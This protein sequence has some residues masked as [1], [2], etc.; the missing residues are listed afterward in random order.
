[1]GGGVSIAGSV[2]K[3]IYDYTNADFGVIFD[4]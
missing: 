4:F 1:L 3:T 2:G